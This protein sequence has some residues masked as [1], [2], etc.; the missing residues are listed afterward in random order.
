MADPSRREFEAANDAY[1]N[2]VARHDGED[3]LADVVDASQA[4]DPRQVFRVRNPHT[5]DIFPFDAA[6]FLRWFRQ[7]PIHP[8]TRYSL[9]YLQ[10]RVDFKRR[11]MEHLPPRALAD[12]TP[13]FRQ[14]L[15]LQFV[16][17]AFSV[18][19]DDVRLLECEA[20]LD[21]ST[22]EAARWIFS[23]LTFATTK[24]HF[25]DQPNGTWLVRRSSQQ[26]ALRAS[27]LVVIAFRSHDLIQQCR[28]LHVHAVGWCW[29]DDEELP[30]TLAKLLQRPKTVFYP[31]WCH[32]LRAF[33]PAVGLTMAGLLKP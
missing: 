21:L 2:A 8:H 22:W 23:D 6:F 1:I 16:E 3:N 12:L 31:T 19:E 7:N 18:A 4:T 9:I 11:C 24:E 10:P 28:V 25:Q 17:L 33:L 30:S 29:L 20:Y 13:A 5:D 27:D 14:A 15:L 32:C 26:S